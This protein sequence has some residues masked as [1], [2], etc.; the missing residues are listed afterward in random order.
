M[1]EVEVAFE[2]LGLKNTEHKCSSVAE[3]MHIFQLDSIVV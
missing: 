3:E 1:F 2:K